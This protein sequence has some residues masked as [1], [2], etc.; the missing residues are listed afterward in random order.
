MASTMSIHAAGTSNAAF[1]SSVPARL[2]SRPRLTRCRVNAA[3]APAAPR[4]FLS[5]TKR[6]SSKLPQ[7]LRHRQRSSTVCSAAEASPGTDL[8]N[9]ATCHCLALPFAAVFRICSAC[10]S[11]QEG[12]S[13]SIGSIVC[14]LVWIQH[15][16]QH[17]SHLS[18]RT[19]LPLVRPLQGTNSTFA[20][21][22]TT[23]K[24]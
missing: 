13:L 18:R 2:C 16:L 22:D 6:I 24:Y 10:T 15:L 1:R 7:S 11:G 19:S 8:G 9:Q 12:E 21:A 20:F 5:G 23:N 17:V 4:G 14:G 3:L